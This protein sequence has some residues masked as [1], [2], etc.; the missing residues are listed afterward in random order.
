VGYSQIEGYAGSFANFINLMLKSSY[1]ILISYYLQHYERI[2]KSHD[3]YFLFILGILVF[4]GVLS[5]TKFSLVLPFI[6]IVFSDYFK[7][8]KILTKKI[9]TVLIIFILSFMIISPLRDV[10]DK[11]QQGEE[12]DLLTIVVLAFSEGNYS[13]EDAL[14]SLIYRVIYLPQIILAINYEGTLPDAVTRLWEYTLMSPINALI[15]RSINPSKPAITFGRWFS[16]NVFGSTINNNIGAT[17][18]GILY[19]NGKLISV[20]I[21]FF[22]VGMAQALFVNMLFNKKFFP[23]Y[24]LILPNLF[25]LPQESWVFYVGLLQT[26]IF[27]LVIYKLITKKT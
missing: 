15:P 8:K 24:L 5:G 21:G 18:Q 19:M 26:T 11:K 2:K 4:V 20:F 14:T 13:F 7:Q 23:I 25:L 9:L 1:L 10:L 16:Y 12:V 3:L 22:L 27:L 6:Y 17:Y